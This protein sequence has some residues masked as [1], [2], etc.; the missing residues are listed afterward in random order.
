MKRTLNYCSIQIDTNVQW[1][2]KDSRDQQCSVSAAWQV[3]N[4]WNHFF[5]SSRI[6][7]TIELHLGSNIS[8]LIG[9]ERFVG[10]F[11]L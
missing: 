3:V 11:R 9:N 5:F 4:L 6:G 1:P 2:K 10:Y 7:Q 8:L